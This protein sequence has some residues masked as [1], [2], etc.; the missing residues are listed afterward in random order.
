ML[1]NKSKKGLWKPMLISTLA[2]AMLATGCSKPAATTNTGNTGTEKK[3]WKPEKPVSLVVT[4]AAGGA[5]DLLARAVEK[6][7]PKYSDAK[8]SV[9]NKPGASGVDGSLFVANSKPDGT[10]IL[11]GFGGGSPDLI[12]PQVQKISYNPKN[13]I[14]PVARIAINSVVIT[15]PA[16]SPF[17]SI[18]DVVA[19]YNTNKKPVTMAV[20]MNAGASD[21]VAKAL[22]KL[23]GIQVTPIPHKGGAEAVTTLL[24]S[25]TMLG[26]HHPAEILTH[27][28]SGKLRPIAV[29]TPERDPIFPDVPTLKEEGINISTWGSPKGMGLPK[30]TSQEI[31]DY[32]SAV[33]EK[34]CADPDFKKAMA[35]IGQPV[36]YLN[37]KDFKAFFDQSWNDYS[38]LIDELGF[39]RAK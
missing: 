29:A 35:E 17:K 6:V 12:T 18:K 21:F 23:G 13:D 39:E 31:V 30:G 2:L 3:T 1:M 4:S 27:V 14:V 36:Q 19:W 10:N 37:A 8:V 32:Y 28:K 15:V 11:V 26:G 38:K 5:T 7:W 25:Q 33:F 9:V 22:G 24:G 34:I 16:D 20:S